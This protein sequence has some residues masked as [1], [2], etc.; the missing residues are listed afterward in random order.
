MRCGPGEQS[1]GR[2]GV[3]SLGE[4][5]RR[6]KGASGEPGQTDRMVRKVRDRAQ[7]LERQIVEIIHKRA[8]GPEP[9]RGIRTETGCGI[10]DGADYHRGSA[11]LERMGQIDLGPK[12]LQTMLGQGQRSQERR[13][14]RKGVERGTDIMQDPRYSQLSCTSPTPDLIRGLEDPH[15]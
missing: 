6:E 8:E 7:N 3:E 15:R 4:A 5:G 9:R 11:L 10:P 2:S 13:G 1:A 14:Q 12:P